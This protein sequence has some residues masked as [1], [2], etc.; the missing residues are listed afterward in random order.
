MR[1][2]ELDSMNEIL[3]N[4]I[5]TYYP[6]HNNFEEIFGRQDPIMLAGRTQYI[7]SN[8]IISSVYT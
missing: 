4:I 1:S 6:C 5:Q 3:G 8:T 7:R 2:K